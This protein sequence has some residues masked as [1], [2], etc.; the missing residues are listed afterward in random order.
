M[1]SP[2]RCR[3]NDDPESTYGFVGENALVAPSANAMAAVIKPLMEGGA[4][5]MLYF[6]VPHSH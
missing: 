6:A 5:R 3:S 4:T 2:L 1:F